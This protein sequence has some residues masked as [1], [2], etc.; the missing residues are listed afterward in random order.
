M[1][2]GEWESH[3]SVGAP[4]AVGALGCSLVSLVLNPTLRTLNV[5][6]SKPCIAYQRHNLSEKLYKIS[7]KILNV[8]TVSCKHELQMVRPL[9]N[10]FINKTLWKLGQLP[11]SSYHHLNSFKAQPLKLLHCA[12]RPNLLFLISD[13]WALWRSAMSA[14]VPECQKLKMVG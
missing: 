12:I 7:R 9:I 13:I 4:C 6:F 3:N 11:F 2:P 14:R 1:H 10:A 8:S 5:F